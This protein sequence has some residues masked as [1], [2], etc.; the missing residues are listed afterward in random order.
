VWLGVDE[1]GEGGG[2]GT[3][4]KSIETNR[5]GSVDVIHHAGSLDVATGS[6]EAVRGL[7]GS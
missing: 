5:G 6:N 1:E 3:A 2:G 4:L 7:Y